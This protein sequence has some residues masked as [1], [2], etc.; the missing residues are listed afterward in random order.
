MYTENERKPRLEAGNK[1]TRLWGRK[2]LHGLGDSG[3]GNLGCSQPTIGSDSECTPKVW[4]R[5]GAPGQVEE[6]RKATMHP[7][8]LL[9][10]ELD[11]DHLILKQRTG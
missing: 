10:S 4:L 3:T 7:H 5:L 11:F 2:E 9:D 8:S 1:D 6:S